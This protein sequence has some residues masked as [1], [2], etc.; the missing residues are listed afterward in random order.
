MN[1]RSRRLLVMTIVL[2][3]SV[4]ATEL[5]ARAGAQPRRELRVCADPANLPYSNQEQQGFENKLAQLLAHELHAQLRYTWWAQR[6]GFFRNTLNT[7]DCDV[8]MGVP[9]GVPLART[10]QPYY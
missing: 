7:G 8:V 2:C 1:M 10:T 9:V 4:A 3:G 6:R 5:R